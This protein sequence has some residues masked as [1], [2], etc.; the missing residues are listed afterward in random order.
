M[1]ANTLITSFL[2]WHEY[3]HG[4]SEERVRKVYEKMVQIISDDM[5]P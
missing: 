2:Y 1:A 3:L 4:A 5:L